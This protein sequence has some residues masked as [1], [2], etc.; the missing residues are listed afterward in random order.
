[1]VEILIHDAQGVRWAQHPEARMEVARGE[2]MG[3]DEIHHAASDHGDDWISNRVVL[4]EE[5]LC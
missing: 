4:W 1:M 2:S 5:R 3:L